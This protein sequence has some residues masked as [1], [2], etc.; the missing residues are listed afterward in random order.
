MVVD[1]GCRPAGDGLGLLGAKLLT[2]GGVLA[3]LTHCEQIEGRLLDPIGSI[4]S[5]AQAADLLYLQHIVLLTE[6]LHPTPRGHAGDAG[7][8]TDPATGMAGSEDSGRGDGV[9]DL[10]LFLQPGDTDQSDSTDSDSTDRAHP[11][12]DPLPDA[13]PTPS[14]AAGSGL[15]APGGAA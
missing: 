10:L 3:V 11:S 8:R 7:Q 13:A 5:S 12:G 4:V 6:R 9:T 15:R 2:T 1:L 14:G